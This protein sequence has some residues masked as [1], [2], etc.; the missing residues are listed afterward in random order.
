MGDRTTGYDQT[1]DPRTGR[2]PLASDAERIREERIKQAQGQDP[3]SE[4]HEADADQNQASDTSDDA[5]TVEETDELVEDTP[6][7]DD[8]DE[9]AVEIAVDDL[10]STEDQDKR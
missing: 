6:S 3:A 7:E 9:V 10:E 2:P 4:G 8:E 5:V 1:R